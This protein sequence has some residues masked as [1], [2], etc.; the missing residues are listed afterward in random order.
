MEIEGIRIKP[1]DLHI[2]NEILIGKGCGSSAGARL[3]GIALAGIF[4]FVAAAYNLVRIRNLIRGA[5]QPLCV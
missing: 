5:P 2:K 1:L 3:A 4:S